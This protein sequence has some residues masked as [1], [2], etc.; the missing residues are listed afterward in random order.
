MVII[1][2]FI[3][4]YTIPAAIYS[5]CSGMAVKKYV[6]IALECAAAAICIVCTAAIVMDIPAIIKGGEMCG[7]PISYIDE[8]SSTFRFYEMELSDE[9][10]YW[11]VGDIVGGTKY[12]KAESAGRINYMPNDAKLY[13]NDNAAVYALPHSKLVY[14]VDYRFDG[15][16]LNIYS[17]N[18]CGTE[19]LILLV[20]EISLL[21]LVY[22]RR[23]M[24]RR[25]F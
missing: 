23:R 15:K 1:V 8:S 17:I 19:L 7:A 4:L 3:V 21:I 9:K 18:S 14:R 10:K 12:L 2:G 16:D 20:I 5:F 22:L 25:G 24:V 6:F 11:G 13:G